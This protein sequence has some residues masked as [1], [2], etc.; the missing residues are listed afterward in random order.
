MV[1]WASSPK[2]WAKEPWAIE[3][4]ALSRS[5]SRRTGSGSILLSPLLQL[6]RSQPPCWF[7]QCIWRWHRQF[8][9]CIRNLWGWFFLRVFFLKIFF[10]FR[11]F[12]LLRRFFCRRRLW[13][14]LNGLLLHPDQSFSHFLQGLLN[15]CQAL[16]NSSISS[17]FFSMPGHHTPEEAQQK[18][19]HL[20]QICW[21]F[22]KHLTHVCC[23]MVHRNEAGG[24][25]REWLDLKLNNSCENKYTLTN[26]QIFPMKVWFD[27]RRLKTRQCE[28]A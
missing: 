4:W 17:T 9:L 2:T 10:F 26:S 18:K 20:C 25:R 23:A 3:P 22:G 21:Y 13:C 11:T 7:F 16:K 8:S 5:V 6:P 27:L 19:E 24:W 14:M 1:W 28:I 12:F 15:L